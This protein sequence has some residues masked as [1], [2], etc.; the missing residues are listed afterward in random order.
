MISS[1]VKNKN[2]PGQM[3]RRDD[4]DD[5]VAKKSRM[6]P[7]GAIEPPAT[8]EMSGYPCLVECVSLRSRWRVNAPG[9]PGDVHSPAH[10]TNPSEREDGQLSGGK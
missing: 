1:L 9:E 5:A 7:A 2:A 4:N 10:M 6:S 8:A 3:G